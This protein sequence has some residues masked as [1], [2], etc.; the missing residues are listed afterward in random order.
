M[1]VVDTDRGVSILKPF[2]GTDK[3]QRDNLES[4]FKLNYAKL[5][6]ILCIQDQNDPII[7]IVNELRE[8]YSKVDCEVVFD[9]C[10]DIV[11]PMVSNMVN[12]YNKVKY[13]YVL[14][15]TSRIKAS[16]EI[17]YDFIVKAEDPDVA[18]IHQL[19]YICNGENFANIIDKISFGGYFA[20]NYITLNVLGACCV[21]GMS[22]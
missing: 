16:D 2:L 15:S 21:T 6:L 1:Q 13:D 18:M 5:Q 17:L 3:Y 11:N 14:V 4:H 7:P 8:Q 12:G 19:P 9:E 20:R 10:V 22:Y